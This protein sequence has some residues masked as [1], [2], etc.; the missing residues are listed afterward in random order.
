MLDCYA[1]LPCIPSPQIAEKLMKMKCF[2]QSRLYILSQ[3][4]LVKPPAVVRRSTLQHTTTHVLSSI[5]FLVQLHL[6]I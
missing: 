5:L 2:A 6:K 3:L 4:S 1:T